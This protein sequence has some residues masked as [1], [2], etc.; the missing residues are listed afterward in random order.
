MNKGFFVTFEGG[1]GAGKSTQ[2]HLLKEYL[3]EQ[4]CDVLLTREPGGTQISEKIR[5]I[6]LDPQNG[7]MEPQTELMLYAAARA[8]LVAEVIQPALQAGTIVI[9][10]RFL[11]SSLAYQ[12]YGRNL[13][14]A[15][16]QVNQYA[17]RGCMPDVTIYLRV[18]PETGR[19]RIGTREQ[20]RI[21]SESEQFHRRVYEGYE[22][23]ARIYP[24]RIV[25]VDAAGT[26]EEIEQ[27]IRA[28]VMNRIHAVSGGNRK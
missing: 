15:V 19:Q 3:Q 14:E 12:A 17:V 9:C 8:Q 22:A 16:L 4:G 26:I 28:E 25:T 18:A 1:D 2:I 10:D 23:L 13:G 6:L 27:T 20:D 24:E 21:E 7:E 5:G 11:D